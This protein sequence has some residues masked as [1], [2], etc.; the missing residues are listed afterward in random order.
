VAAFLFQH[1]LD[2]ETVNC[3]GLDEF[4]ETFSSYFPW[5]NVNFSNES[6][7]T[8]NARQPVGRRGMLAIHTPER[9]SASRNDVQCVWKQVRKLVSKVSRIG[10]RTRIEFQGLRILLHNLLK[11]IIQDCSIPRTP[12][13]EQES[14]STCFMKRLFETLSPVGHYR[15]YFLCEVTGR[16]GDTNHGE[17]FPVILLKENVSHLLPYLKNTLRFLKGLLRTARFVS[18]VSHTIE[19]QFGEMSDVL[20]GV[21]EFESQFQFGDQLSQYEERASAREESLGTAPELLTGEKYAHFISLLKSL[22]IDKLQGDNP[23]DIGLI[24]VLMNDDRVLWVDHRYADENGDK[25]QVL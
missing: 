21:A 14:Q 10:S 20:D 24:K 12:W 16:K 7:I 18:D 5:V 17:G 2:N 23:V 11:S 9:E 15:L 1:I 6:T 8:V 4:I 13:L 19:I 3:K 25:L 22:K